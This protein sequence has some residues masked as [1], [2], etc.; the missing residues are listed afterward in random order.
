MTVTTVP[1][2]P[3][4][5]GSMIKLWLV[6]LVLVAGAAIL[7]WTGTAAYQFETT[8]SGLQYQVLKKG[9]GPSPTAADVALIDYTGKLENGTEF[10]S[11]KGKQPVP[12]PVQGSIAG[13][14]E[15]LQL[16]NKGATYR[17]RIP[18]KLAYG[19]QGAGGVIP[20][21]STLDFEVTLH[22][23]LPMSSL[24]GMGPPPSGQPQGQ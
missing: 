10:D 17:F 24:Q 1:L 8:E 6:L 19:A 22:E 5:K 15:G 4:K 9:E 2:R 11:T 3:L 13:F 12:L 21:N 16:M 23:F 20:P 14:S 7:A 18:P